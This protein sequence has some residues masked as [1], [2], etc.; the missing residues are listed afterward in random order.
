MTD[1]F[2]ELT[3][4]QLIALEERLYDDEVDGD[5]NWH[6]RDRVL[7]EMNFRGLCG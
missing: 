5:D 2:S 3:D 6:F 4:D 7:W 1:E